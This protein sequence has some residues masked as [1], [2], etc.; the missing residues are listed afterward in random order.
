MKLPVYE[1]RIVD[2]D[3][4]IANISLVDLPAVESNFLAFGKNKAPQKFAVENEEQRMILGVLMRADFP[5]YRYSEEMGE[6]YLR[7]SKES[8]RLMAEKLFKDG[9]QNSVNIMHLENSN[10]EGVNMVQ[11]FIKDEANGISPAGFEDI[12]DGSLFAQFKVE[13]DDIWQ[14]IK[15]GT[16]KGF[17]IEGL[18]ETVKVEFNKNTKIQGIMSKLKERLKKLL[19]DFAETETDKG[20]LY[21]EGQL[22][23]GAEV[24][25]ADDNP[26]ADGEY[27]TDD[28]VI[29]VADGKVTEIREK[30]AEDGEE[31]VE[32]EARRQ[33]FNKVKAAFE[34]SYE[35]K[36]R[37]IYEAI[38]AKGFEC[39]IIEAGDDFAVAEV[40][41]EPDMDY[42]HYRFE[43]S[44]DAEGNA[45]VS[46][47]VEVVSEFVTVEEAEQLDEIR[48][49]EA[50]VEEKPAEEQFAEEEAPAAE[51][52]TEEVVDEKEQR[53]AALEEEVKSIKDEIAA[54][55]DSLAQISNE[56]AAESVQETFAK[57][58]SQESTGNRQMDNLRRIA[59]ARK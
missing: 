40:W 32:V 30:E 56:P 42:K 47:P 51:E 31:V 39:W 2:W 19:Q 13:N 38:A 22:E 1:A 12:E 11:A 4:G 43:V 27:E 37:R 16:F 23:I 48:D 14:E 34:E 20:T 21:T 57:A 26:A 8:V 17:S 15:D 35:D 3:E 54:L 24:F 7:F 28:K 44:W 29:V 59:F 49:D 58:S 52:E 46:D 50:V 10:V 55:K 18:F 41:S 25:D 45:I 53:I 5:I 6:Y 9:N 33:K 36:E